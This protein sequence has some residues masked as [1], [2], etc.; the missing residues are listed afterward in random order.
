M[1]ARSVLSKPSMDVG[2]QA[3]P[4]RRDSPTLF[5]ELQ[6]ETNDPDEIVTE[7]PSSQFRLGYFSLTCLVLNHVMGMRATPPP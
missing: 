5:D 7:A 4:R 2:P 3:L 6:E 1:S